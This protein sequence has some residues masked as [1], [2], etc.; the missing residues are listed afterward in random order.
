[1]DPHDVTVDRASEDRSGTWQAHRGNSAGQI[2]AS[3][4]SGDLQIRIE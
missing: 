3:A 1:M 2:T 4:H